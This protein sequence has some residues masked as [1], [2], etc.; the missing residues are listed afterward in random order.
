[1]ELLTTTGK[2]SSTREEVLKQIQILEIK[3]D[4]YS[5]SDWESYL[6]VRDQLKNL[7]CI[8]LDIYNRENED[9]LTSHKPA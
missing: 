2:K 8:L 5:R 4:H 6:R 1:M 3:A 9:F 7:D